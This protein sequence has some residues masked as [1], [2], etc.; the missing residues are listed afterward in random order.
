M[1][2][3]KKCQLEGDVEKF[4]QNGK[5]MIDYMCDYFKNVAKKPVSPNNKPGFL[6]SQ[7]PCKPFAFIQADFEILFEKF[8]DR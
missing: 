3:T 6:S 5:Q 8:Y 1:C 7:L 4:R 2:D